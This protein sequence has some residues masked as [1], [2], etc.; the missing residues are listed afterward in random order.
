M[1]IYGHQQLSLFFIPLLEIHDDGFIFKNKKYFWNDVKHVF[2]WEPF[3]GLGAL[4]GTGAIPRAT[5]ELSDGKKIRIHSS[6]F[7]KEGEIRK[8]GFLSGKSEAFDKIINLF[9]E[10]T[11]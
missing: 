7:K 6:V 4:L 1:E 11:A 9:K 3:E 2:I 5:I 10:K 8:V